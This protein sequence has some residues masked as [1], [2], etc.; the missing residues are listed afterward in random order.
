MRKYGVFL[1]TGDG[2][3]K[4]KLKQLELENDDKCDE[5]S[6][7]ILWDCTQQNELRARILGEYTNVGGRNSERSERTA[8]VIKTGY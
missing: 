6:E 4:I 3:F 8:K 5:S 2:P 7:L 1:V